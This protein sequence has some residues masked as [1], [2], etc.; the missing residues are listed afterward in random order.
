MNDKVKAATESLKNSKTSLVV[1]AG[2]GAAGALATK[3]TKAILDAMIPVTG[4]PWKDI[5]L[6]GGKYVLSAW[7]GIEVDLRLQ[8][9]AKAFQETFDIMMEDLKAEVGE[10]KDGVWVDA[11]V[12]EVN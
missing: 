7:V 1:M 8:Q 2:C 6:A 3:T 5:P 11:T 4:N 9:Q 10:D 12:E